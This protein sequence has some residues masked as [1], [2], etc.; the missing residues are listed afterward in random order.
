MYGRGVLYVVHFG[1]G[2]DGDCTLRIDSAINGGED[3]WKGLDAEKVGAEIRRLRRAARWSQA[4]LAEEAGVRR[5]T[6]SELERGERLPM[7]ETLERIA[8]A[9]GVPVTSIVLAAS[10]PMPEEL[11][12]ACAMGLITDAT[13]EELMRLRML[14]DLL[15]READPWDYQAAL[16]LMRKRPRRRR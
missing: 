2:V 14:P 1:V 5:A 9:L 16:M 11:E 7:M 8:T 13:W 3:M 6:I 4:T 15:G 10:G 12:E